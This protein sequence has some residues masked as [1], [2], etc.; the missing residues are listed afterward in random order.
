MANPVVRPA[1]GFDRDRLRAAIVELQEHERRLHDTRPPGEAMADAYLAWMLERAA[2]A[3]GAVFVA[4]VDGAFAGF[5]AGWVE[6]SASLAETPDSNRFGFA[7]DLCVL[8]AFRGRGVA[9]LLLAALE[10]HLA[11]AGVARVRLYVLATNASARAAYER[12]GYRPY[13]VVYE[14]TVNPRPC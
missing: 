6:E 4:E 5:A 7:S 8:P 14:K 13:E 3:G 2:T 10:A 1:T 11:R 12:A 9:G